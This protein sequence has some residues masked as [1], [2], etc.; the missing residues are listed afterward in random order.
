MSSKGKKGVFGGFRKAKNKPKI[1]AGGVDFAPS[2]VDEDSAAED[3]AAKAEAA[4]DGT[5]TGSSAPAVLE[6]DPADKQEQPP[7]SQ[8]PKAK[9]ANAPRKE[10]KPKA[11]DRRLKEEDEESLPINVYVDFYRGVTKE[12]DAEQI[13]RAFVEKNYRAPNACYV[14]VQKWRDGCA[15]EMQEGGGKAYLP[16]TLRKLDEDPDAAIALPMSNRVLL[17][18]LNPDTR[19]LESLVLTSNQAPPAEAFTA[20]PTEKMSPFDKRGSKVFVAGMGLLAASL[21]ALVFSVGA[22]FIDT[23]AWAL[24]YLQQTRVKDLPSAQ[25]ESLQTVLNG[26]DC[27]AKMEYQNGSWNILPGWDDGQ[28]NCSSSAPPMMAPAEGPAMLEPEISAGPPV[29]GAPVPGSAGAAPQL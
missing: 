17:I 20:L 2:R 7:R 22:F 18:R 8:A 15:V 14:Y 9:V 28:G 5:V 19:S 4:A 25:S 1:A 29:P 3:G 10:R 24:P 27:I 11:S 26:A 12:R 16:E 21:I 23:E 13:A 6:P